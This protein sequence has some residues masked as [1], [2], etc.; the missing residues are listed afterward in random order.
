MTSIY[1]SSIPIKIFKST[2]NITRARRH[3]ILD[4]NIL[5]RIFLKSILNLFNFRSSHENPQGGSRFSSTKINIH[6]L[7]YK[8]LINFY[9]VLHI[10][11]NSS[12]KAVWFINSLSNIFISLLKFKIT[13]ESNSYGFQ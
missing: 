9:E 6:Y 12:S 4:I 1:S 11:G 2:A 10:A 13:K 7:E 3:I 8:K 5:Y